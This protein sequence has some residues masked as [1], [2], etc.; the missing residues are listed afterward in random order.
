MVFLLKGA[1][2]GPS[3]CDNTNRPVLVDI[4]TNLIY[5]E[6]ATEYIAYGDLYQKNPSSASSNYGI[7]CFYTGGGC[8]SG[9][10]ADCA[11]ATYGLTTYSVF[12]TCAFLTWDSSGA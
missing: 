4:A 6:T 3:A 2:A 10:Y 12:T 11:T 7:R 8:G 1:E 9:C 5:N